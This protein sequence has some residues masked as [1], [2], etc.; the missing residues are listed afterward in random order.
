MAEEMGDAGF[1]PSDDMGG[2]AYEYG[3][4]YG[5]E[6]LDM[7]FN[8][9]NGREGQGESDVAGRGDPGRVN[10]E[11]EQLQQENRRLQER[12]RI[13]DQFEQNPESVLRDVASRMGLEL[14]QRGNNTPQNQSQGQDNRPPREFLD[15][16]TQGLPEEMQFMSDALGQATWNALQS[17]LKPLQEQ[18]TQER[19]RQYTN[20]RDSIVAEMDRSHPNWRDSVGEME[21]LFNFIKEAGSGGSMRH[22]KYGS[23]QSVLYRLVSGDSQAVTTAAT[24]M[25]NAARQASSVSTG[26]QDSGTNVQ[27]QMRNAKSR[28]ERMRI[29]FRD[30][31]AAN[32]VR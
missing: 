30:A 11:F 15:S 26:G 4:D 28:E 22:P 18:Q 3:E 19:M 27:Q 2:E 5:T 21:G 16:L 17:T 12:A 23:L 14:V 20:E 25:R 1:S 6:Q 8:G 31:L 24:R 13:L 29:A 10:A 32:G 7:G 9:Q